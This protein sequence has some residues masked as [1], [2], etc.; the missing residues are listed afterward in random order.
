MPDMDKFSFSCI[1]GDEYFIDMATMY[2]GK[3]NTK[4]KTTASMCFV[5]MRTTECIN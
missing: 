1:A 5:I 2:T 4:N 3:T